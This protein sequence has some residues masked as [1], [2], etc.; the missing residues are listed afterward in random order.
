M[1]PSIVKGINGYIGAFKGSCYNANHMFL[2][3][4]HAKLAKM[5]TLRGIQLYYLNQ[6]YANLHVPLIH[7]TINFILRQKCMFHSFTLLTW[8][9]RHEEQLKQHFFLEWLRCKTSNDDEYFCDINDH[10]LRGFLCICMQHTVCVRGNNSKA[11]KGNHSENIIQMLIS[12]SVKFGGSS[13]CGSRNMR[14][15]T[16][17]A[18]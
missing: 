8:C 16:S 3:L 2:D 9:K 14:D 11:I 17:F 12:I 7:S 18:F 6:I 4:R 10:R 15:I 13:P 1:S 5:A